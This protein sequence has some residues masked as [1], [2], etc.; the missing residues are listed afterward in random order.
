[1]DHEDLEQ[2]N[3]FDL[4]EMDLKW[5]GERC[6]FM[7]RNLLDLTREKLSTSIA[8]IHDTLLDSADQKG[9]KTVEGEKLETLDTRQGTMERDL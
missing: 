8:I 5:Q 1:M 6:I 2:V 4:E 7:P 9:I 3:E